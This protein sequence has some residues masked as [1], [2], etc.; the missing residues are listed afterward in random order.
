MEALRLREQGL[1]SPHSSLPAYQ[2]AS[3]LA[4]NIRRGARRNGEPGE[5]GIGDKGTK[6]QGDTGTRSNFEYRI[7]NVEFEQIRN[8][9]SEIR[10]SQSTIPG[11]RVCEDPGRR[12]GNGADWCH[13]RAAGQPA[14]E[15]ERSAVRLSGCSADQ[16]QPN[17]RTLLSR[18][19]SW[20][21][22]RR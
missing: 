8:H 22:M 21:R 20:Q 12:R 1:I 19:E 10:H 14:K 4:E 5:R 13:L 3:V 16:E 6:R 18:G 9:Q 7:S 17:R 11:K 15:Q 2:R